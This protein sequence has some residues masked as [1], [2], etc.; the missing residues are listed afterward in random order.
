M[1]QQSIGFLPRLGAFALDL[2]P[3]FGY[4]LILFVV[5]FGLSLGPLKGGANSLSDHP[6]LFDLIVF[7]IT[8]L[9][10]TLY[11]AVQESSQK[12]ASWGKRRLGLQVVTR[13]GGR[14]SFGRALLRSAIKFLPWQMA[15]TCLFHIPGWPF[16]VQSIPA[17]VMAGFLTLYALLAV[18]FLTLLLKPHRT[19]YD[20]IAGTYVMIAK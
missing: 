8:I 17:G 1:K 15:H 16:A 11:F 6:I 4:I 3:I 14:L 20:L 10:V 13:P 5:G 12:M 2:I 18:Y 9:P 19:F 7:S